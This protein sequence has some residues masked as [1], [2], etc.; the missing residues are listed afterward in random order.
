MSGD[1]IRLVDVSKKRVTHKV[2]DWL[3]LL[4]S[5]VREVIDWSGEIECGESLDEMGSYVGGR[6]D[7]W[8]MVVEE[9]VTHGGGLR[10]L[11][12]KRFSEV[13]F[14]FG[15]GV[16]KRSVRRVGEVIRIVEKRWVEVGKK[17]SDSV[18]VVDGVMKRSWKVYGEIVGVE[19]V[20]GSR[21]I[22][23]V[24]RDGVRVKDEVGKR[25]GVV[26]VEIMAVVDEGRSV[27]GKVLREVIYV[28]DEKRSSVYWESCC[29]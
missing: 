9:R 24:V 2:V 8:G 29:R 14:D 22:G 19:D 1:E 26:K 20:E 25:I 4:D 5:D 16:V 28:V 7:E 17:I 3:R 12:T 13:M 15:D 23:K 11:V 10:W 27:I 6:L 18:G 21:W